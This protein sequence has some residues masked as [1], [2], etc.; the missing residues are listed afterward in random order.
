MA[1]LLEVTVSFHR[2]LGLILKKQVVNAEGR[3]LPCKRSECMLEQSITAESVTFP[4]CTILPV[5]G[6][7]HAE[8]L[9][10]VRS[11]RKG[12]GQ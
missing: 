7:Q 8:L 9:E 11:G 12:F 5:C 6:V 10:L 2:I 1:F 4:C 3:F